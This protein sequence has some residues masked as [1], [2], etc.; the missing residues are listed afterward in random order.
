M[1]HRD[2]TAPQAHQAETEW[3]ELLEAYYA[4]AFDVVVLKRDLPTLLERDV[5]GAF[6]P[7]TT[8]RSD[9]RSPGEYD[10]KTLWQD[11]SAHLVYGTI[12]AAAFRA[13]MP[14]QR[15]HG[16]WVSPGSP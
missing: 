13:L 7:G 5:H 1:C 15:R 14:G 11:L 3:R 8:M 6:L 16:G 2:T 4:G 10:P 12:T 9:T